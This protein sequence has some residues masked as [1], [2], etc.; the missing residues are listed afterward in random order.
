MPQKPKTHLKH[1]KIENLSQKEMSIKK[2]L[3]ARSCPIWIKTKNTLQK[4]KPHWTKT[5]LEG[6]T[7]TLYEAAKR[8]SELKDRAL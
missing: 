7:S 5:M 2:K 4:I 6:F 8:L 3:K 1:E